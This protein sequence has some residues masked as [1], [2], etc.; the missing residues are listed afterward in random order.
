MKCFRLPVFP[1]VVLSLVHVVYDNI[2]SLALGCI[3]EGFLFKTKNPPETQC[4]TSRNR[5]INE[6]LS[7][8]VP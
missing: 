2:L 1:R 3:C 7:H 4:C 8:S 5:N 6:V